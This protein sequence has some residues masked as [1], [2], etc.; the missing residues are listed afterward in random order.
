MT[1]DSPPSARTAPT[2]GRVVAL[3]LGVVLLAV[4]VACF[5]MAASAKFGG[6]FLSIVGVLFLVSGLMVMAADTSKANAA[7]GGCGIVLLGGTAFLAAVIG[8]AIF[9]R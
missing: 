4:A 9:S 1:D 8:A 2:A 3:V 7:A 5:S 6:A